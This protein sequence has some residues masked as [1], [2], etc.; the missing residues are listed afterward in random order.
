MKVQQAA[1]PVYEDTAWAFSQCDSC[2]VLLF[3]TIFF[4]TP[5]FL[6]VRFFKKLTSFPVVY[7][8][9]YFSSA[10]VRYHSWLINSRS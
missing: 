3:V 6:W 4:C 2:F 8:I 1:Y 9:K 10:L 5:L 7:W